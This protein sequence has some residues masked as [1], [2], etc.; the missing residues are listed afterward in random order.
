MDLNTLVL[1]L[2]LVFMIH[3]FEEIIFF[4]KWLSNNRNILIR[5]F[6]KVATRL[7]P[8]FENISTASF[9]LAV[10]EEFILISVLSIYTACNESYALWYFII[11][12]LNLL[13]LHKLIMS[14]ERR[15]M[16]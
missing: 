11:V 15:M 6:P 2:P 4:K 12:V 7:L 13:I 8:H 1:I 9:T 10:A 16:K 14:F 3:D 5:R